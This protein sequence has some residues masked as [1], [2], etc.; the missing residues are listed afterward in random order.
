MSQASPSV[1]GFHYTLKDDQGQTLD[2]S[3]GGHPMLYLAGSGQILPALD[4][5]LQSMAVGDKK[6]VT[7]SP[8]DGYGAVNPALKMNVKLGQFPDGTEVKPGLQF[9]INSEPNSPMFRV[10]NVLGEEVF[11]DGN[12]PM[13]GKTLHFDVEVLETRAA[14]D[15]ELAHG[16]AH[17]AGGHHH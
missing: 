15:E 2:S 12:H 1:I 17:G 13:A 3:A 5:V 9:R 4:T 7:L 14:T 8:N 10:I 6:S 16:H 11:I